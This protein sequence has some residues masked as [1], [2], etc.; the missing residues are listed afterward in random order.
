MSSAVI[1]AYP[2]A[3]QRV[4]EYHQTLTYPLAQE[5]PKIP[6]LPTASSTIIPSLRKS[7]HPARPEPEPRHASWMRPLVPVS[8]HR[9]ARKSMRSCSSIPGERTIAVVTAVPI[10]SHPCRAPPEAPLR[11][12]VRSPCTRAL[13]EIQRRTAPSSLLARATHPAAL[14]TS[15]SARVVPAHCYPRLTARM[16]PIPGTALPVVV[17]CRCPSRL[18]APTA[19]PAALLRRTGAR[20]VPAHCYLRLTAG[21]PPMRG[22]PRYPVVR[23]AAVRLCACEPVPPTL[24]GLCSE[25]DPASAA[26]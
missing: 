16:N 23:A 17:V 19:H 21:V 12:A 18:L 6:A 5:A 10:E 15:S 25:L 22:P 3:S 7:M 24:L 8:Q 26:R 2:R 9:A 1:R 13:R 4:P 14:P 20:A 11:I